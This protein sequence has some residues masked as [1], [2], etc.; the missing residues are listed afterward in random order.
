MYLW[1]RIYAIPAGPHKGVL[2]RVGAVDL[3]CTGAEVLLVGVLLAIVGPAKRRWAI[4]ALLVLGVALWALRFTNQVDMSATTAGAP[5]AARAAEEP[6]A[7][8]RR[9]RPSG[10]AVGVCADRGARPHPHLRG[11]AVPHPVAEH[12]AHAPARRPGARLQARRALAEA[13]PARRLP[14]AA[15]R[16][17]PPE[18]R[19]RGRR[20]HGRAR[21]RRARRQRPAGP[22]AVREP[23]GDRQR[24]LRAGEGAAGE[25]LRDGR[26]PRELGGLARLR[27]RPHPSIIGR[28]VAR[29]WP[30]SRWGSTG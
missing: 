19:R 16:R 23:Q 1:S 28:S 20:R 12:G 13:R 7:T 27:R 24:L 30:P 26:Q 25:R 3:A 29:V 18:A 15:R 4:N 5:P 6:E 8:I 21:G 9:R 17:D 10:V 14:L 2:E 11:R 22:R